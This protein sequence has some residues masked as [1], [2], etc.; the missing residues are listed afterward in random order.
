MARLRGTSAPLPQGQDAWPLL[1]E[2]VYG[3]HARGGNTGRPDPAL[4]AGWSWERAFG[5][6]APLFLEVGF[7]RGK[8]ITAL[9]ERFPDHNVVGIE[10]RRKFAWRLS[11]LTAAAGGPAHLRLLWGDAKVL[12][13]DLFGPGSLQGMFITFPDPWWKRRH[14][15]RRLVDTRFAEELAERVAVGG[16]VWVKSDV[17]LIAH[18][19]RDALL[20]RPEFGALTPFAQDDLPLTYRETSCVRHGLPVIRFRVTRLDVPFA[21]RLDALYAAEEAA[22]A[23]RPEAPPEGYVEPPLED[24]DTHEDTDAD[25]DA[26]TAGDA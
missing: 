8:F 16:A 12:L 2:Q 5:R 22:R 20:A 11:Q 14:S 9:A 13:A 23:L 15:K 3:S 10:I 7:N 18:E 21:G 6:A 26:D 4:V 25:A 24:A 1:N 17:E 19:I